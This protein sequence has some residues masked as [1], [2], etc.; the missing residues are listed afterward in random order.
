M[1]MSAAGDQGPHL[2]G[3]PPTPT[4]AS[5]RTGHKALA[6]WVSAKRM[7]ACC[8]QGIQGEHSHGDPKRTVSSQSAECGRVEGG[9]RVGTLLGDM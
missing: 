7:S 9:R 5:H 4:L 1:E 8:D 3:F 2:S 6:K